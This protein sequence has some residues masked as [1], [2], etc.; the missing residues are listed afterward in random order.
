MGS[1]SRCSVFVI[2]LV[3]SSILGMMEGF[4][5][6]FIFSNNSIYLVATLGLGLLLVA[7]SVSAYYYFK[8]TEAF[9]SNGMRMALRMALS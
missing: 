2:V 9:V 8:K 5:L 1:I 6:C 7:S 3:L 4:A